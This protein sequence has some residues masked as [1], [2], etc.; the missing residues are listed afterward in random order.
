MTCGVAQIC[1]DLECRPPAAGAEAPAPSAWCRC[2][3]HQ[4]GQCAVA[5][6]A[7]AGLPT[8]PR[9]PVPGAGRGGPDGPRRDREREN[10]PRCRRRGPRLASLAAHCRRCPPSA[11]GIFFLSGF[12]RF[13]PPVTA[14][15][16]PSPAVGL[17]RSPAAC[18][19]HGGV[20]LR[21]GGNRGREAKTVL[22]TGAEA[23]KCPRR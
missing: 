10:G 7:G 22:L 8:S 21:C 9:R 12:C 5:G 19:R 11:V 20:T 1:S 13:R 18:V 17:L 2:N 23:E 15:C 6:R 16:S 3:A 14:H 4:W